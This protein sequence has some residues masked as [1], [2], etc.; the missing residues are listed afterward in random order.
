MGASMMSGFDGYLVVVG[1]LLLAIF[2]IR[3]FLLIYR[4]GI[5]LKS[6]LPDING[7]IGEIMSTHHFLSDLVGD[8]YSG[9]T[10]TNSKYTYKKA[11]GVRQN[12]INH[13]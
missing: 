1:L 2:A 13:I 12:V 3:H 4:F 6:L 9:P 8:D 7:K 10:K 11:E 5:S